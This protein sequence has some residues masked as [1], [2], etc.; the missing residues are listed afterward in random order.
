M[1]VYNL[2][3]VYNPHQALGEPYNLTPGS[4]IAILVHPKTNWTHGEQVNRR[5]TGFILV[6]AQCK[7][8]T[9][10]H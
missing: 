3:I 5:Y 8:T 9:S 4:E 10:I 2:H 6:K 1:P 7:S